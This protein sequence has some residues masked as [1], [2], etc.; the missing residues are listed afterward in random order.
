MSR[1]RIY[2]YFLTALCLSSA[3]AAAFAGGT[4]EK[5][6]ETEF[7]AYVLVPDKDM[8]SDLAVTQ[9]VLPAVAG[10]YGWSPF[11]VKDGVPRVSPDNTYST[12]R[13]N[14]SSAGKTGAIRV[15]VYD[16]AVVFTGKSAEKA[17]KEIRIAFKLADLMTA[18]GD[19]NSQP[20]VWA[21]VEAARR[22][23]LKS[24]RLRVLEAVPAG[25]DGYTARVEV[26]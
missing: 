9:T 10:L 23:G 16:M 11:T 8:K 4:A 15:L 25:E 18:S 24:G 21:A 12:T 1:H 2:A 17:G 19:V 13:R 7:K 26:R 20:A 3:A 22:S 5:K 14:G 6:G